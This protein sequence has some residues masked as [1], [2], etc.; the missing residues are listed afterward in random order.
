MKVD[1]QV[2]VYPLGTKKVIEKVA[3]AI[4]ILKQ[5]NVETFTSPMS[6]MFS[7]ELEQDLETLGKM[8]KEVAKDVQTIMT[9]T[10]SNCCV[11]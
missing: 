1:I 11:E 4:Q 5:S 7:C 3:D 8:F 6:T 10:V 2:S 9:V